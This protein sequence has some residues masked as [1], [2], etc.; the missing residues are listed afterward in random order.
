[1]CASSVQQLRFGGWVENK[2]EGQEMTILL[3]VVAL[4][5]LIYTWVAVTVSGWDFDVT[6]CSARFYLALAACITGVATTL[7][8]IRLFF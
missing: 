6:D 3:S 5:L 1:M 4:F 8:V 2:G 7:V